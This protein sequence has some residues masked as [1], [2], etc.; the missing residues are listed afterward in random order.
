MVTEEPK[1]VIE[2]PQSLEE[3]KK[4]PERSISFNENALVVARIQDS[5][6]SSESDDDFETSL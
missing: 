5:S 1:Q 2:V 6:S 3:P 4:Q